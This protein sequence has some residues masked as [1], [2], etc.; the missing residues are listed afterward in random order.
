MRGLP[1]KK[2]LGWM[3]SM[4][5]KKNKALSTSTPQTDSPLRERGIY[6][7]KPKQSMISTP[8]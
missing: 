2:V 7:N 3:L 8:M 5:V 4:N 6:S 1:P